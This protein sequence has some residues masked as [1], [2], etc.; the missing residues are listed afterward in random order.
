MRSVDP[1]IE[2]PFKMRR[3]FEDQSDYIAAQEKSKYRAP[4]PVREEDG[5]QYLAVDTDDQQATS[6]RKIDIPDSSRELRR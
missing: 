2:L 1:Q 3:S 4:S 6:P 5:R